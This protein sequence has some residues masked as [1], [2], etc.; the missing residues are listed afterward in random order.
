MNG[1]SVVICC[2]N[3]ASRIGRTLECI[4]SQV[5]KTKFEWEVIVV[6]NLSAD[7]TKQIVNETW[8]KNPVANLTVLDEHVQ[9]QTYARKTGVDHARYEFISFVDDDNRVDEHW[10]NNVYIALL[11]HPDAAACNGIS[12][13][14]FESKEPWWFS[15]FAE[16]FAV[17]N[18][19][20]KTGYVSLTRAFLF[21]AGLSVRKSALLDLYKKNYP[22]IQSGRLINDLRGGGED[23]ELCFCFLLCG[24]RLYYDESI[25]FSHFMPDSRMT[26]NGLKRI[27]TSLGRDEVVLSIY[28]SLLNPGFHPKKKWW[29]EYLA[30]MK[31]YLRFLLAGNGKTEEEK[32]IHNVKKVYH[33]SYLN[34]LIFLRKK[35]DSYREKIEKFAEKNKN[36]KA[37]KL[38]VQFP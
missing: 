9:G 4:Q 37:E 25:R 12:T 23:S 27:Q 20:E 30:Y 38:S 22:A 21:G 26:E 28:R 11:N 19:G 34:E 13:A 15:R 1:V 5:F 36:N 16:N 32:F 31:Y 6:D 35:Y 14:S 29:L 24:Y 8:N 2:Y 7:N 10:V 3:S 33:Q 18:Q 17:G